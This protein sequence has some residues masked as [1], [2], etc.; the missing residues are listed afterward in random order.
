VIVTD[1]SGCSTISTVTITT[2][3]NVPSVNTTSTPALCGNNNGT[4]TASVSG[5][6]SPYTYLWNN[7]ATTSSIT[8]LGAGNYTVTVTDATGCTQT[9][10][11]S[12]SAVPGPTATV[13]SDV[14]ITTGQSVTLTAGGGGMYLWNNG[15]T[16]NPL[17]V[18]PSVTTIYCVT[19]TDANGCSDTACVI[20]TV[21]QPVDCDYADDQLFVPDA[22]S[23]N[24]DGKNDVLGVYYPNISCIKEFN[25]IIYDRWG[26]KVFEA[27][28]ITALWDGTYKGKPMNTAVFVYYMKVT[29]ITGKEIVRKGN[30]SLIR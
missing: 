19:V 15:I 10:V 7:G 16:G 29:L 23:P 3:G 18:S 25:L 9:Q 13:T 14:T 12:V 6:T 21:E 11:V 4:A 2:S 5:G 8:G 30:V 17:I 1:A 27:N 26:E 22:F 20:V 28:N 24:N